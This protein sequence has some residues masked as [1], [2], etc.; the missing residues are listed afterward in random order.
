IMP[1]ARP[2]VAASGTSPRRSWL[3]IRMEPRGARSSC[4]TRLMKAS[5]AWLSASA[6]SKAAW[7]RRRASSVSASLSRRSN[8]PS[9]WSR[10]SAKRVRGGDSGPFAGVADRLLD[11]GVGAEGGALAGHRLLHLGR[12]LLVGGTAPG[13]VG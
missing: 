12:R 1:S 9:L 11:E 3:Q 13:Y 5:L 10:P 4:E 8:L 7:A 2:R 6:F